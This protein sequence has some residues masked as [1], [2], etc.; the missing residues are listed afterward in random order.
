MSITVI[1]LTLSSFVL[2]TLLNIIDDD[3]IISYYL[4]FLPVETTFDNIV[5]IILAVL[6]ITVYL[7][8]C[9]SSFLVDKLVTC[10]IYLTNLFIVC[11]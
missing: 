8:R 6:N 9:F 3:D 1:F 2:R 4:F 11:A 7:Q 5:F 10:C